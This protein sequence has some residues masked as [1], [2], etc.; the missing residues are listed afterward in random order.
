ML[1]TLDK[2]VKIEISAVDFL[3]EGRDMINIKKCFFLFPA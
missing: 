1:R 3:L 2:K